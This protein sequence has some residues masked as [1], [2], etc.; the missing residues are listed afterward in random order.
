MESHVRSRSRLSRRKDLGAQSSIAS[1]ASCSAR[2]GEA[3]QRAAGA[4]WSRSSMSGGAGRGRSRIVRARRRGAYVPRSGPRASAPS[5]RRPC[6]RR[7]S[8]RSHPN[9]R[10]RP[11]MSCRCGSRRSSDRHNRWR[12]PPSSRAGWRQ[13]EVGR[14]GAEAEG[15]ED[16]RA[17]FR[18]SLLPRRRR[19]ELHPL[20][21]PRRARAGEARPD[22]VLGVRLTYRP[23]DVG[24]PGD[25]PNASATTT[26]VDWPAGRA[27][28]RARMPPRNG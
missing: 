10:S 19:R 15:T 20:R 1:S 11:C 5:R 25:G 2:V 6:R 23:R 24:A 22:D 14:P 16:D 4:G 13:S 9:R 8:S 18:G 7:T 26:R 3:A 21:L 12:N 17:A 28:L 27:P